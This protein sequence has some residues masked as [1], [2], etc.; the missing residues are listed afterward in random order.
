M[1]RIVVADNDPDALDLLLLDLRLE[2]HTVAGAGDG[3]TARDLVE[4]F[5]ADAVVLDHRMPPGPTGLE[6]ALRLAERPA[7]ARGADLQ[8]LPGRAAGADGP[9]QRHHFPAERESSGTSRR[10]RGPYRKPVI[11]GPVLP[12]R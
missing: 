7:G 8:Q 12:A 11:F 10:D 1:A 9:R 5:A 2:G 4:S 3:D 6:T